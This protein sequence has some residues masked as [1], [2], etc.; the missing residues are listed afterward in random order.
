MA[1]RRDAAL[2]E[3]ETAQRALE[4]APLSSPEIRATQAQVREEWLRLLAGLRAHETA[5]GRRAVVHASE[6]MLDRLDALTAAYE[7]SMQVIMG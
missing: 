6:T 7:H 3:F 2:D 5:D 4:Q 1:R